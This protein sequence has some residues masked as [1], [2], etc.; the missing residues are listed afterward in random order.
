MTREITHMK[1]FM[2]ALDAMGKDPLKI[3]EI[4]PTPRVVN[5]FFNDSTGKGDEGETDVRGPWNGGDGLEYVE[6]P[7]KPVAEGTQAEVF[8]EIQKATG[9]RASSHFLNQP[10]SRRRG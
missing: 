7:A 4:P 9:R 2:T 3:G 8:G 6:A 10:K 5:K 1:A